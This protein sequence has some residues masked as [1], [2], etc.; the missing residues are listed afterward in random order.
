MVL[1]I[2]MGLMLLLG[3]ACVF[4]PHRVLAS[5]KALGLNKFDMAAGIHDSRYGPS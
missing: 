1:K 2:G 3:L 4:V 5:R